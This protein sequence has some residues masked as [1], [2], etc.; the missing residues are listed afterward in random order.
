MTKKINTTWVCDSCNKTEEAPKQALSTFTEF[1]STSGWVYLAALELHACRGTNKETEQ[2]Q[3]KDKHL[4]S[5]KC[6]IDYLTKQ[7]ILA[8]EVRTK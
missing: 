6:A 3:Q 2:T 7:V 4:C 5:A 8:K 1:P